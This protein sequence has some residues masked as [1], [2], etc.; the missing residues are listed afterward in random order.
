MSEPQMMAVGTSRR[1]GRPQSSVPKEHRT[2]YLPT[3]YLDRI[4]RLAMRHGVSSSEALR[5]VVELAMRM[6]AI[7]EPNK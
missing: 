5:K 2:F 1:R 7:T 6:P 3:D 4:D